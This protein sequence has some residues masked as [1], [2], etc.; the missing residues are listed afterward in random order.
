[1]SC[2]IMVNKGSLLVV[3]IA[4]KLAKSELE[5]SQKVAVDLIKREGRARLL[6]LA[7]TFDGWEDGVDWGELSFMIKYDSQI[8]RIAIVSEKKWEDELLAFTG[9]GIRSGQVRCFPSNHVS[10]ARTWVLG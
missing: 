8:E 3:K 1:M 9:K 7:Q 10:P 6:I 2:E 4:G 5:A